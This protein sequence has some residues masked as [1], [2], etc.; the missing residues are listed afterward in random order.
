MN[1]LDRV[2]NN[3]VL[4][5]LLRHAHIHGYGATGSQII[6]K[7][8][9]VT[10]DAKIRSSESAMVETVADPIGSSAS[11][12]LINPHPEKPALQLNHPAKG[13]KRLLQTMRRK[14]R[15]TLSV[16]IHKATDE[17][18]AEK[19][20]LIKDEHI[21]RA[22]F[23]DA[24]VAMRI[25]SNRYH[26]LMFY[27]RQHDSQGKV[28]IKKPG[29]DVFSFDWNP[30]AHTGGNRIGFHLDSRPGRL[31][32]NVFI[33]ELL[34]QK[35][36]DELQ[37]S[38]DKPIRSHAHVHG[39]TIEMQR[40]GNNGIPIFV[41]IEEAW[42]NMSKNLPML[43]FPFGLDENG[44]YHNKDLAECPHLLVV[45]ATMQ[46]KSNMI[47]TI[48]CTYLRNLTK[49][50]VQFI[51]F[52][53]KNGM[54]FS[55]FDGVPHLYKDETNQI[56]GIIMELQDSIPALSGLQRIMNKRMQ[57]IRKEGYKN[58][59]DYNRN[60]RGLGR[61]PILIVIFDDYIPM[62]LLYGQTADNLLIH[63][64]SQARAAG[65]H[66]ILGAQYPKADRVPS[67]AIL[68]FQVVIAFKLKPGASGALLGDQSAVGLVCPGRAVIQ[69]Q[70]DSYEVQTPR[71]PDNM[72]RAAVE[73]AKHPD[74]KKLKVSQIDIEEI[75]DWAMNHNEGHLDVQKIFNAFRG[76]IGLKKLQSLLKS[77]DEKEFDING[78][79]FTVTK[80]FGWPRRMIL[81]ENYKSDSPSGVSA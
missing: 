23:R 79:M 32:H 5:K 13:L 33:G 69:D 66:L 74:K 59:T 17:E 38:L 52:D 14:Y 24:F 61:M 1:L 41:P 58:I 29:F 46:G 15:F 70:G 18:L 16:L 22:I 30:N 64:S 10:R 62:S 36:I 27:E 2:R 37:F 9:T 49:D 57:D 12:D 55:F 45:G 26:E 31:P 51:L 7:S 71:I 72:I 53:C 11:L 80:K 28:R 48:I 68:N 43:A 77:A 8:R 50:Q 34:N 47:N 54:E 75:L 25:M 4:L 56:P 78:T 76:K 20:Q 39:G 40:T 44:Q 81:T 60:K 19:Q 73:F 67:V 3:N 42:A 35:L 63:L 65:I 6:N 21:Q